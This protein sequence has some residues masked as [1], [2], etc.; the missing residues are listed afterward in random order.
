MWYLRRL[1]LNDFNSH[2]PLLY[3]KAAFLS[4]KVSLPSEVEI[5]WQE[6]RKLNMTTHHNN[7]SPIK[8]LVAY[9]KEHSNIHTVNNNF[10]LLIFNT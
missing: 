1:A 10:K 9:R 6:I 8:E 2:F 7:N 3:L 5:Y 4:C